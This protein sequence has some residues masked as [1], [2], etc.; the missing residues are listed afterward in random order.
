MADGALRFPQA[1]TQISTRGQTDHL[2]EL[3]CDTQREH[4]N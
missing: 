3:R 1:C 4:F 2:L